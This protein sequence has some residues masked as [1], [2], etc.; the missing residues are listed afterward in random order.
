M[1]LMLVYSGSR[2]VWCTTVIFNYL[3]TAEIII[4]TH[5]VP[6]VDNDFI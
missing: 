3:I 5:T 2:C 4:S 6:L 1:L